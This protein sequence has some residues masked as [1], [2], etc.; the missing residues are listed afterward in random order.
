[1]FSL[2]VPFLLNDLY[3]EVVLPATIAVVPNAASGWVSLKLFISVISFING[4]N[5]FGL[6]LEAS[7]HDLQQQ[8]QQQ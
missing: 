2:R 1:M 4:V 7:L 3:F 6:T 5:G 8:P